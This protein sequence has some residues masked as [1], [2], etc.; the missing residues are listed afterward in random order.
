MPFVK[1]RDW[2]LELTGYCPCFN[3]F[4]EH[5]ED[6]CADSLRT[7]CPAQKLRLLLIQKES[8]G[9]KEFMAALL[10]AGCFIRKQ[11]IAVM[12]DVFKMKP[13]AAARQIVLTIKELEKKGRKVI[14]DD[15]SHYIVY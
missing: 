1:S 4:P 14:K 8:P 12:I 6:P 3:T 13:N 10:F 11:L 9:K 5:I 15:M 2:K 7:A